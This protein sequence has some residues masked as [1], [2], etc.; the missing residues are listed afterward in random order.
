[1]KLCYRG[2]PYRSDSSSIELSRKRKALK[3]RGCSYES[4]RE[5]IDVKNLPQNRV[6]YRGVSITSGQKIRF[7]GRSCEQRKIVLAPI[8]T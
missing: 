8:L 5:V 3:F 4:N 6:V 7:L 1:M 2:I